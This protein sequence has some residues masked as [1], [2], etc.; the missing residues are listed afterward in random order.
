MPEEQEQQQ[1][2]QQ[3]E[4]QKQKVVV[5]IISD[6]PWI[7]ILP[8]GT[9]VVGRRIAFSTPDIPYKAIFIKQEEYSEEEKW[10]RIKEEIKKF[11]PAERITR[12]IE[13]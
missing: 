9:S 2:Q 10:R 11:K 1:E 13:I 3:T 8:D 4:E 5:E 7:E 6:E 12:E